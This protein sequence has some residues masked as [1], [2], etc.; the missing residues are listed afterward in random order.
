[1][2]PSE[3]RSE[4]AALR[5]RFE[6]EGVDA[7]REKLSRQAYSGRKRTIAEEWVNE[8]LAA[9]A[10]VAAGEQREIDRSIA[11]QSNRIS[12][13]IGVSGNAIALLALAVA[14][15]AALK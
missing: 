11:R 1:M 12:F 8:Q 2:L 13:W 4:R 7:I 9:Q 10:E 5:E 6:A 15:Y 14:V 3:F